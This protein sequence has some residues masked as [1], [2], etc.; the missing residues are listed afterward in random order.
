MAAVC[1]H[2]TSAGLQEEGFFSLAVWCKAAAEARAVAGACGAF[3]AAVA[4][5][6]VHAKSADVVAAACFALPFVALP[7]SEGH[8]VGAIDALLA[9]LRAHPTHICLQTNA[10][11]VLGMM[12]EVEGAHAAAAGALAVII[13]ALQSFP[14]SSILQEN[15]CYALAAA[16]PAEPLVDDHAAWH[17]DAVSCTMHALR[18]HAANEGVQHHACEA[19]YQLQLTMDLSRRQAL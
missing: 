9:V 4:A 3:Q 11:L 10:C 7:R 8:C 19:L 1:A 17:A 2:P 14:D 18:A 5:L 12:C 6:R 15:A 16:L 13:N